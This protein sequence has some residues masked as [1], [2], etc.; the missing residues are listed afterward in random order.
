MTTGILSAGDNIDHH[1]AAVKIQSTIRGHI[2]RKQVKRMKSIIND[3][4]PNI[5][6][7]LVTLY[8]VSA[9]I[10]LLKNDKAQ[11]DDEE[12]EKE[13][14]NGIE[15]PQSEQK[16]EV[17]TSGKKKEQNDEN[18]CEYD[19]VRFSDYCKTFLISAKSKYNATVFT[20]N[21]W[22]AD[23][24]TDLYIILIGEN[25]ESEKIWLKQ[26]EQEP[27]FQQ[28]QVRYIDSDNF[29]QWTKSIFRLTHSILKRIT[30]EN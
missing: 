28:N 14:A 11:N 16:P 24:D 29:Q 19:K 6:K 4:E 1:E 30:L 3:W 25:A 23:T 18:D 15:E 21:R 9:E 26:N 12:T 5:S 13:K 27:K 20:G 7:F 8:T 10:N 17:R 22:A 2:A